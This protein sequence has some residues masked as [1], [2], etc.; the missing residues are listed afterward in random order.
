M[1]QPGVEN[2]QTRAKATR[3]EKPSKQVLF[4]TSSL[5]KIIEDPEIGLN[6]GDRPL[7]DQTVTDPSSKGLTPPNFSQAVAVVVE[8]ETPEQ[9]QAE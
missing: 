9:K 5:K 8:E 6:I 3:T 7:T 1:L 4:Q 2:I